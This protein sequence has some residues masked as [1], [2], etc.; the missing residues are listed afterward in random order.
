MRRAAPRQRPSPG[1][2]FVL[3]ADQIVKA[4]GQKRPSLAALL[5]LETNKGFIAVDAGF[6]DQLARRL[7]H[8][9][10]HS[11]GRRCIDRHGR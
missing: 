11:L 8:R 1:S 9:R 6:Q 2:E 5:G 4:I 10:L 3:K 7:C